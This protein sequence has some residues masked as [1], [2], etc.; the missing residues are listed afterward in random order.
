MR[1]RDFLATPALLQAQQK[2]NIL[3]IL[4]DDLGP[5]LSCYGHPI[6]KTPN[7]DRLAREGVRFTRAHTTAPVCSS[8]RSAFNVGLY[9]TFTGTH[10]HRS[11]RDDNYQLPHN[12]KLISE[13]LAEAGYFTANV[14]DIAPGVRGTAK[15]DWNWKAGKG[16][17]GNHWRQR[18]S[19]QP[20]YAQ[21][22]FQAPHKGPAFQAARK[23]SNL[24][25]PKRVDLPPYYPDD[26]RIRDEVAN[27]YDAIQLLDT[28][29]GATLDA[30]KQDGVLDNTII[31]LFGD[32][33]RCLIRG[34]Q[35]LYDAG[36]H[37]P[38]I[39]RHPG[40]LKAGTVREDPVIAMDITAQS[41]LY[42]GLKLPEPFHGQALFG[43]KPREHI[44]TARDRCDMTVDRIRAVQTRRFKLIRNLMP[45]KPYTQFNQYI[46]D[47]YPTY[48]VL[49]E[50]HA[51]GKLNATQELFMAERKPELEFYDLDHDPHEVNNL[52]QGTKFERE[53]QRLLKLLDGWIAE[54]KEGHAVA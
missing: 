47:Q 22:N 32:N 40:V 15:T 9:Q 24:I 19:G 27:Y 20:F 2:P 33:G 11:H 25:D 17:Q 26:P 54:N 21:I 12:A 6:V 3:W 42:A 43:G 36:T 38:L 14:T 41:L 29:V 23:Q 39:V 4:G 28:Q 34:K 1:R 46:L 7:M 8:S 45:E 16:F 51:A 13:R 44:F 18:Q 10:D 37:V 5:Q 50:L 52:A 35:W 49:K 53:R 30:L 31:F 48:S